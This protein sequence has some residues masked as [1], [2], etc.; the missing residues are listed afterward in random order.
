[1]E[2]PK[3]GSKKRDVEQKEPAKAKSGGAAAEKNG[4]A[5]ASRTEEAKQ[6]VLAKRVE[7]AKH[8]ITL[9]ADRAD[10]DA[11]INEVPE[12][13][14]PPMPIGELVAEARQA[15]HNAEG[16]IEPLC[17]RNYPFKNIGI[18]R[19]LVDHV[20]ALHIAARADLRKGRTDTE[21]EALEQAIEFREETLQDME[22]AVDG[23]KEA[24]EWIASVR[25][26]EGVDDAIDD[27]ERI[28][29]M[30]PKLADELDAV[31]VDAEDIVE[32][33]KALLQKLAPEVHE[34]RGAVTTEYQERDRAATALQKVLQRLY[35]FGKVVFRKQPKRAR[36]YASAYSR[37][38]K[39]LYRA[40]QTREKNKQLK[41]NG[42]NKTPTV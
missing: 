25:E 35:K 1:M 30:A 42:E 17:T 40:K 4:G 7:Q 41:T 27:L 9:V 32:G 21:V 19:A 16:D 10:I 8:D 29:D 38:R 5:K 36:L 12:V 37:T 15:I 13:D 6:A 34:R 3:S 20:Q 31:G 26:N 18:L 22:L 28:I 14:G 39:A 23:E 24:T 33:A 2:K 11:L